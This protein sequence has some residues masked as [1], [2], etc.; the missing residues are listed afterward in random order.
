MRIFNGVSLCQ[1]TKQYKPGY[2]HRL[3]IG[4]VGLN[5]ILFLSLT[6]LGAY[7]S[8]HNFYAAYILA[9][10]INIGNFLQRLE[11]LMATTWIISTYFKT[12]LYF[13]AFVL[14]T[15]QLLKLKSYRPLI[16]P[17]AFLLYGL[18]HLIAKDIIFYVKEVPAYW[19]DWDFT[20]SIVF[21]LMLLIVY[22]I[23][24]ASELTPVPYCSSPP[25]QGRYRA[26]YEPLR[27]PR[28]SA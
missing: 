5:L 7:F 19:V 10:R 12:A 1:K 28:I 4:G 6:V 18:T 3:V 2:I 26:A 11:A 14:G 9:Q 21:P 23:K 16:F 17:V 15:A 24:N 25:A 27:D 22:H 20:Y 8:E 13:Y